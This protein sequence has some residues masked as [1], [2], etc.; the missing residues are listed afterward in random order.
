VVPARSL[1]FCQEW[2]GHRREIS[3]VSVRTHAAVDEKPAVRADD[4]ALLQATVGHRQ[5][6]GDALGFR[7]AVGFFLGRSRADAPNA[8]CKTTTINTIQIRL[9]ARHQTINNRQQIPTP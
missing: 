6:G 9:M 2:I 1:R 3:G 7:R 8:I 4:V 5:I